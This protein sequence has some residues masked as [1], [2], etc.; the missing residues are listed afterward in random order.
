MVPFGPFSIP[1]TGVDCTMLPGVL[2]VA[3]MSGAC[4]VE[5]CQ[6]GYLLSSTD[7]SRCIPAVEGV[8]RDGLGHMFVL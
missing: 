2:D 8:L 5:R 7:R 1:E 6:P 3:C 4:V